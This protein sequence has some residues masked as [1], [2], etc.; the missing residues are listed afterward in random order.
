MIGSDRTAMYSSNIVI[1]SSM[2]VEQLTNA[3]KK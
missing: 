2:S 1:T 3:Y